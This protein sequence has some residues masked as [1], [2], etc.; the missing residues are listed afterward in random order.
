MKN[1]D[2]DSNL[3]GR[4]FDHVLFEYCAETIKSRFDKDPKRDKRRAER[5]K[6]KCEELKISLSTTFQERSFF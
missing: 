4:D 3:G 2:G 6:R 5:I 1:V